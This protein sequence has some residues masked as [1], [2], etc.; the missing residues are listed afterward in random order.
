MHQVVV[1]GR[2]MQL[3]QIHLAYRNSFLQR[4]KKVSEPCGLCEQQSAAVLGCI[5]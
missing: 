1:A 4:T 5:R 3:G 2:H